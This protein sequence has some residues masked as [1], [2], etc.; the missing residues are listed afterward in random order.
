MGGYP[1]DEEDDVVTSADN[2]VVN[3]N[4]PYFGLDDLNHSAWAKIC[5]AVRVDG[6]N[7]KLS[8]NREALLKE[9]YSGGPVEL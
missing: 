1:G 6:L 5:A 8:V 4:A 7:D 9:A 3:I 2:R